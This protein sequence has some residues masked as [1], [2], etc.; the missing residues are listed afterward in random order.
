MTQVAPI[1]PGTHYTVHVGDSLFSIAHR[2]YGNGADWPIIYAANRQTIGP[3]PNVIRIGEV[4]TI[5]S[6][7]PT[8][9][10]LYIVQQGDTLTSIAQRAYGDGKQ[11]PLIYNANKQVIGNNPNVIQA[12]QVL[13]IPPAPSAALP[14]R[15][16][17]EIQGD[18]LAGFIKDHRVYLFYSFPDQ[19]S[20]RAWLK[21]LIP[22]IAKTKDVADFNARFSAARAANHGVDPPNIKA[23]WVNISLTFSGL[24]T[25]FNTHSQATSDITALF[26]NFAQ[27]PAAD[28]SAFN[29]GDKDFNNLNDPN[30]LSDPKN[31][32]F[33]SDNRIHAMLNIQSDDPNALTAKVQEQQALANKHRVKQVF[34]QEGETLP[35][36]LTGHEH[37]GFKDGISQPGVAGFDPPDPHDPKPDPQALLGHVLGSPGTEI[38]AAGEFIL[39]ETVEQDPTFPPPDFSNP[40]F[41][42]H[43]FA[44]LNW[45]QNGSFQVV[46]RLNQ[47]VAG[48]W[49]GIAS[50][51]PSDGSMNADMLGAKVVG[52]WKSGTPIDLSPDKDN[53]LT[54]DAL[55]NFNFAND[56]QGLR[57]PRFAHIRKV[58]PRDHDFVG[59]RAKRIIRRGIPFGA[60]FAQNTNAERGLF[61][62]AYMANVEG[63]FEFLMGTWVNRP[64]F[65]FDVPQ[66][67]DV[68][69]GS[70]F[71]EG[72]CTIQRQGK[73]P[74]QLTFKRFVN[75]TGTLYAFAPSIT[76]LTKLANGEI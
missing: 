62:V 2:A 23:T 30:N 40:T 52:R 39:G 32:K 3:N 41:P 63:Q 6:L 5:P 7:S 34:E 11:W 17:T 69:I 66:G 28:G 50:A 67:P 53:K 74:L 15:N 16:S 25:L 72:P 51:V 47:N 43:P 46:R 57:C 71:G 48:F 4:L 70:E 10:E 60:P 38:I 75:T 54:D 64:D 45:M 21:E 18:I 76:A 37:F 65:P 31:W 22:F 61:F 36:P 59:N 73:P 42:Q 58:Y 68:I 12:G 29:N 9:G 1:T 35:Q 14:L 55:N 24:T 33:G 56:D 8:P 19:A 26:P 13:Q 44:G 27:G 49:D 20:G